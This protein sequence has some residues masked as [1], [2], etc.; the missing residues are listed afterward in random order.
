MMEDKRLPLENFDLEKSFSPMEEMGFFRDYEEVPFKNSEAQ[1]DVSNAWWM[2]EL[3]RLVY[4]KSQKK[5]RKE[6]KDAGFDTVKFFSKKSTQAFVAINGTDI[7][8]AFR[9]TELDRL[10]DVIVDA[11]FWQTKSQTTGKI[12]QGFKE[13]LDEVWD[14]LYEYVASIRADRNLWYT[15]HSLGAALAILAASRLPGTAVYAFGSPRVGNKKF[16]KSISTPV[17]RI[18][19]SRDIVTRIPPPLGYRHVGELYFVGGL[20]QI[21]KN[22]N[23]LTRL[24]DRIGGSELKILIQLFKLI[25]LK[26]AFEFILSYLHDHSIYNYSVYMWN[27]INNSK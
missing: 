15:G 22:P 5:V 4:V 9:G 24:Y 10:S 13:A 2:A 21:R 26:S 3:S 16:I 12:H 20:G 27:N 6:L 7:M 1:F 18:A 19:K 14:Q 17:Y 8:V 23:A 25:V 11:R